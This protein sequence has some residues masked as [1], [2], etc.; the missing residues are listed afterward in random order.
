MLVIPA[1]AGMTEEGSVMESRRF[2][3]MQLAAIETTG[4]AERACAISAP[5]PSLPLLHSA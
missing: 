5:I 2:D 1:Q 4:A 3:E